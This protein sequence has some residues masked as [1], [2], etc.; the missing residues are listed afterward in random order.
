MIGCYFQCSRA[1]VSS[2]CSNFRRNLRRG[3]ILS[4]F[5]AKPPLSVWLRIK[6]AI[7]GAGRVPYFWALAEGAAKGP[8]KLVVKGGDFPYQFGQM[9]RVGAGGKPFLPQS[10]V[11]KNVYQKQ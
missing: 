6:L 4:K 10:V 11:Y 8:K 7:P 9:H 1:L 3:T 5:R 2:S